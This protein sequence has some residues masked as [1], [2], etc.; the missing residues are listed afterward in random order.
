[1]V[2]GVPQ[3]DIV[4]PLKV[5]FSKDVTLATSRLYDADFSLAIQLMAEGKI[6]I[7]EIITHRVPLADA[8]AL[9]FRVLDGDKHPIKIMISP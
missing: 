5:A 7:R 2:Y 3:G 8:P 6:L 9:I 4:F 1:V